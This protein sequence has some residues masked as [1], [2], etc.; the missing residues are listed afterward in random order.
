[1]QYEVPMPSLG[2]DMNSGK[3]MK[4]KIKKGDHVD[5]GQA[6][7]VVET[8]KSTL[9]IENFHEGIVTELI[10]REGD[11]IKVGSPIAVFEVEEKELKTDKILSPEKFKESGVN[12]RNS[13]A[14]LMSKSKKEIPHYYLKNK[15]NLSVLMNWMDKKNATLSPEKRLMLTVIFLKFISMALKDFPRLNGYF[16]NSN[17]NPSEKI[18]IGT[19]IALK[20]GGVMAPALRDIEKM[21]LETLQKNFI[22]LVDRARRSELKNTEFSEATITVTNLGDFGVDEVFGVIFPPQVAILGIGRIREEIFYEDEKV[23]L[24][25]VCQMT[26]S[27]DHRV[28][29]G[30]EGAR[31][32]R[33]LESLLNQPEL[34]EESI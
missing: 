25:P 30:L 31:F 32:L 19:A 2:A 5:K 24:K 1:M 23:V 34:L 27:A 13:I 29:D 20:N 4:W 15:M 22:D 7:A 10:G 28:S 14:Q 18:N 6:L 11:E 33:K 3:L 26:L 12:L 16:E 8:T 21:N 17:F 9:D